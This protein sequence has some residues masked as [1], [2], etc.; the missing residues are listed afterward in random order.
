MPKLLAEFLQEQQEPFDLKL[1]LLERGYS[2]TTNLDA[3]SSFSNSAQVPKKS[4]A[5]TNCSQLVKAA[6]SSLL[7][8]N[9]KKINNARNGGKK[10]SYCLDNRDEDANEEEFCSASETTVLSSC[11]ESD[12][13]NGN[14]LS[15]PE[16]EED[17]EMKWRSMEDSNKQ[18]SPVSV[19][20]ETESDEGSTLHGNNR[21]YKFETAQGESS[22]SLQELVGSNSYAQYIINKRVLKQ[23]KRLLIDCV[24][25]VIE[26]HR[27][28]D[29]G[30]KHL[31]NIL[32]A[33]ELWKLVC[34][35]VWIWSQDSVDEANIVHLLHCDL[36]DSIEEWS[37]D[38]EEKREEILMEIGDAILEDIVNE[39]VTT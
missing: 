21:K 2:G 9:K 28:R 20:E 22:T 5:F 26:N 30:R 39:I 25:E 23:T 32:G 33:D 31:K 19:L 8:H 15:E 3:A 11:A 10:S 37:S 34:E 14:L 12:V 36:L 6:F 38:F 7:L 27:K 17:R 35:N 29:K 24:R 1:Y 4:A 18:L 13:E 16:D